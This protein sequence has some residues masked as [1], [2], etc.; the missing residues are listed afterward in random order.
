MYVAHVQSE[1]AATCS[2][3]ETLW[4][5]MCWLALQQKAT[6]GGGGGGVL[7][8]AAAYGGT[9]FSRVTVTVYHHQSFAKSFT[10]VHTF[11]VF[12]VAIRCSLHRVMQVRRA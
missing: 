8:A 2:H 6:G 9:T 3:I 5:L 11:G 10:A 7:A 4:W 1:S 12:C